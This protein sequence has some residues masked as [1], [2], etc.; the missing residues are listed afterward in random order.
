[1][2]VVFLLLMN[3]YLLS[4]PSLSPP[5]PFLSLYLYSPVPLSLFLFSPTPDSHRLQMIKIQMTGQRRTLLRMPQPT[6]LGKLPPYL[7]PPRL[8]HLQSTPHTHTL[9]TITRTMD[10][11]RHTGVSTEGEATP[12]IYTTGRRDMRAGQY[13]CTLYCT[14]ICN[15]LYCTLRAR[16]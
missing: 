1:M 14:C 12:T 10:V 11:H 13:H 3:I 6:L 9:H 7:L 8:A 5:S 4:V 15:I 2:M 16:V